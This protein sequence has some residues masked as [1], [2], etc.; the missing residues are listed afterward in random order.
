VVGLISEKLAGIYT[1]AEDKYFDLLDFFDGKGI[2][3][4][5]Y[6]DFFENRGIPSF[7]VTIAIIV[8]ILLLLTIALT[9]QGPDVSELTLSLRD[10]NGKALQNVKIVVTDEKGEVLFDGIK[11]DGDKVALKRG[12]Y[13]GEKINITASIDGYQPKTIEFTVGKENTVPRISFEKAFEGIEAKLRIIDKETKT[14]ISGATVIANTNDLS[15]EFNDDG[16]GLYKKSGVPGGVTLLLKVNAEGYNSYEQ[17]TIFN[18]GETRTVELSPS[19][20]GFVGKAS[21]AIVVKNTDGKAVDDAKVTIYDKQTNIVILSNY[22]SQGIVMGEI[23]TGIPLRIVVEKEGYLTYDSDKEGASITIREKEKQIIVTIKQG[24]QNLHVTVLDSSSGFAVDGATVQV[25]KENA[26]FFAEQTSTISGADFNGLDP[27]DIIYVTAYRE[28]YLP[29]REKVAVSS[30][31][32]VKLIMEKITSTNSARLDIYAI[33]EQGTSVNGV[34]IFIYEITDGNILPYGVAGLETSF[35]GYAAVTV[36]VDKTYEIFGLTDVMEGE[37]TIEVKKGE[38]DK[39]VYL[40]MQKKANVIEMKFIDVYG[41]D[42]YGTATISGLDGTTIYDGNIVDSRVFFD[43]EQ[44][45]VVEVEVVLADGNVFTE[46]VTVKGKDYIEVVVYNK[47]SGALSPLMEFIG[48]EDEQG[49]EVKGITPGAFYWAKFNVVFPKAATKGGVHFRA[50]A[51]NVAFSESE[52]FAVYDLSLQGAEIAQSNSYTPTPSPGNETVDRSNITN[53]GEKSKWI[54]GVITQPNG[55]YT[56]KVKVRAEDFTEGKAQLHYRAWTIVNSD[57][58]RMPEDV[59][60][61]TSAFTESK[62]GLYAETSIQELTLYES[63]PECKENLCLTT[64]FID[65]EETLI[66]EAGFEALKDKVYA[67]EIEVTALEAD[68]VQVT[69][70]TDGNLVE[71]TSTQSGSFNFVRESDYNKAGTGASTASAALSLTAEGKEK[72]RFYFKGT[73]IGNAQINVKVIGKSTVE[74]NLQFKVVQEKTLLIELSESQIMAG[75]NFTVKVLDQGLKGIENALVKIIDKEGKIVKTISGDGSDGKGKNGYYRVVNDLSVGLYTVEVSVPT[76]A[77]NSVPLLVTTQNVLSFADSIEVK[78]PL[79]Q[80]TTMVSELLSN[81]SEFTVQNITVQTDGEASKEKQNLGE[82]ITTSETGLFKI[83]AIAPPALG[84]EQKQ[85]VQI[86]VTFIGEDSDSADETATLT[87]SGLVEG[88]FLTKISSTVHMTYN[89]KLDSS[90]LKVTPSSLVINLLGAEGSTDSDVLEVTNNCD[91]AVYLKSR[92]REI[93][94]KSYI[95]VSTE[96]IDLQQGETKNITVTA[97]NLVE[98]AAARE[99]SFS[100]ELVY[101]SNYLKKTI[102]VNVKTINPAF[103]LSYPPQVTLWLAQSNSQEKAVAAQPLFVTNISSFPVENI[104]FNVDREYASGAN[105][106]LSVEPPGLVSLERGQSINPPKLVFAQASSKISEPVRGKILIT[107]RMGQLNNKAGQ[108]DGYNYYDNYYDGKTSLNSY[109]PKT[110]SSYQNTSQTLGMIDVIIYYSGF[111]CLTANLVSDNL[112][113]FDYLFPIEGGQIAKKVSI[114]NKCAEPVR[115]IGATPAGMTQ[116]TVNPVLGVPIVASSIMMSLPMVTIGPGEQIHVPMTII[117]AIPNVNRKNYSVVINAVSEISQ[118]PITSKPFNINIYSGQDMASEHVKAVKLKAKICGTQQEEEITVPK[119]SDNANCGEAYCDAQQAAK[120][121]EQ[122]IRQIISKAQSQGYSKK[123]LEE[124]FDCQLTGACTFEEIGMQPEYLDLYLQNDNLSADILQKELNGSDYEASSSTPFRET[125]GSTGFMVIP[126]MVDLGFL[127]VRVLSGYDRTIFLDRELSGC[128]YYKLMISG[129]FRAG[130]DGIDAM[131]PAIS[132][133]AVP[134]SGKSKL[135]TK[136]CR[137]SITNVPNFNPIDSGLESGSDYGTWLTTVESDTLLK[138]VAKEIAKTRYKSE[139][140]VTSGSGN[141]VR[142]VQGALSDALAQMCISGGEK[143]TITVT[144]DSSIAKA[145]DKTTKDTYSQAIVKLVSDGLT[146]SFG[147]NCLIKSGEIY[148]CVKLTDV[149]NLGRR[150]IELQ[151]ES[152]PL[153]AVENCVTGTVYSTVPEMLNFDVEPISPSATGKN[154]SNIGKITITANDNA[155][156]PDVKLPSATTATAPIVQ[157]NTTTKDILENTGTEIKNPTGTETKTPTGTGTTTQD[158]PKTTAMPETNVQKI[159]FAE[160]VP[161]NT[162]PQGKTPAGTAPSNT[163]AKN[164]LKD[165]YSVEYL[166][167]NIKANPINNQVELFA[168]QNSKEYRYY[169]NI[170]ICATAEGSTTTDGVSIFSQANGVQF[171]VGVRALNQ[172]QPEPDAKKLITVNTG[173]IHPDDLVKFIC[174]NSLEGK[175]DYSNY[176][177]ITWAQGDQTIANFGDYIEGLKRKGQL[178]SCILFNDKSGYA[179]TKAY[180]D[181]AAKAKGSAVGKYLLACGAASAACNAATNGVTL[182]GPVLGVLLDCGVPAAT[183]YK[184]DLAASYSAAR[185]FYSMMEEATKSVKDVPIIGTITKALFEV[186]EEVPDQKEKSTSIG[187]IIVDGTIKTWALQGKS[188]LFSSW[189]VSAT[190]TPTAKLLN[191]VSSVKSADSLAGFVEGTDEMAKV[192]LAIKQFS[193]ET[194]KELVK[195]YKTYIDEAFGQKV[196]IYD[197]KTGALSIKQ[198]LTAKEAFYA[199]LEKRFNKTIATTM[200]ATATKEYE[201]ASLLSKNRLLNVYSNRGIGTSFAKSGAEAIKAADEEFVKIL[202][203]AD[204]SGSTWLHKLIGA[205]PT[206]SMDDLLLKVNGSSTQSKALKTAIT[207]MVILKERTSFQ[208]DL[209]NL[210]RDSATGKNNTTQVSKIE[211]QV[212]SLYK[213][214]TGKDMTSS[215]WDRIKERKY[216]LGEDAKATA[217]FDVSGLVDDIFGVEVSSA[218]LDGMAKIVKE[219][220]NK[221]VKGK[222]KALEAEAQKISM[223]NRL[224]SAGVNLAKGIGCAFLANAA[225]EWAYEKELNGEMDALKKKSFKLLNQDMALTKNKQ[226]ELKITKTLGEWSIVLNEKDPVKDAKEMST[227]IS[228]NN[229]KVITWQAINPKEKDPSER[230]LSLW[231]LKTDMAAAKNSMLDYKYPYEE[232]EYQK[233][234]STLKDSKIEELI[235]NYTIVDGSKIGGAE[236]GLVIATMLYDWDEIRPGLEKE[237]KEYNGALKD[238]VTK[239]VAERNSSS[240]KLTKE[241]VKKVFKVGEKE[242]DKFLK[243]LAFWQM[244]SE[245]KSPNIQPA[246]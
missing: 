148:S 103:A 69:A 212:K 244:V 63:L 76:Y 92:V 36:T 50:G 158:K 191:L 149:A 20:Q 94:K 82:S 112:G 67:L 217:K 109:T 137:D 164:P 61:E 178:E 37:E 141:K 232:K 81:N 44:R 105:I 235:Y 79:G 187:Q 35:A 165:F 84:K 62:S 13:D 223:N 33:D 108:R 26:E 204:S 70:T 74:K 182:L 183:T 18:E 25:F 104:G 138:D 17:Q 106:Q 31:E 230:P 188:R 197:E 41:K 231:K 144:V 46:N 99:Q 121:L 147:D 129:A 11:S 233:Q 160:T 199:E 114:T 55:T 174:A 87:I 19:N 195:G 120:Y 156:G 228:A 133:R 169:R 48:I 142:L 243:V 45:E 176:F 238:K 139:K 1:K 68:Y 171:T 88:K 77:T 64:N 47:D 90:C 65:E 131:T 128:G 40:H 122:K 89:R 7:V 140:R 5:K 110:T 59:E 200:N 51:D 152:L 155:T 237:A 4:Y 143:K 97:N 202:L 246:S 30:T 220:S 34:K 28:G 12:L 209:T 185:G 52:K 43:A 172:S 234:I 168:N 179:G 127:K 83:T 27:A 39:K 181:P 72:I 189:P 118:T 53:Q 236:E 107:G 119:V 151:T 150:R 208:N 60:L 80:K 241:S 224:R 29:A 42:I 8:L 116:Q 15:F 163:M 134:Q 130:V 184:K 98:R 167:G 95:I 124:T 117:T 91:Q 166:G 111:N 32:E 57:Y 194:S 73:K 239:L 86:T 216:V 6:S 16:N 180:D 210:I 145:T 198:T 153:N 229:G 211:A 170:K 132:V 38:A 78:L 245:D 101:D 146:G 177:T 206:D 157:S 125:A 162:P 54:E 221:T 196:F 222:I 113:D 14:I 3:V 66:D 218:N 175:E 186:Q 22:T 23:Q 136:E 123:N 226:Y 58:Y 9:Y 240:G 135:I 71:F 173:T 96:D 214:A 126:E 213:R 219:N 190:Q 85:A 56:V 161:T 201:S 93:T 205:D 10:A 203:E 21:V 193:S 215:A 242:A 2:P 100:Y 207:N 154:F 75:K 159:S 115:V 192:P 24:G 102:A 227:K 49:T 225:G